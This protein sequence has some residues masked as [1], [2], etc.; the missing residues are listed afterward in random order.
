MTM[1]LPRIVQL[2][3]LAIV[4]FVMI[5]SYMVDSMVFQFGGL[6]IGAAVFLVGKRMQ[7]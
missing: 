3:G 4:T 1:G 5:R 6:A 2:S 7:R